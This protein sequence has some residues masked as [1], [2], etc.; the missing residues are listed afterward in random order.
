MKTKYYIDYITI[1]ETNGIIAYY[2]LVRRKDDAI[3][4][5][6]YSLD[7]VFIHC[8]KSGISYNDVVVL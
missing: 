6:N 3:L 2:Q 5:S 1:K 7:N 8:W 4:Y